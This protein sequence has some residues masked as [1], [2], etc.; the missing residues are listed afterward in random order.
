M[1]TPYYQDGD[2]SLY[3]ADASDLLDTIEAGSV[4]LAFLDFPYYK[5]KKLDWD[6]Q[7]TDVNA[8]LSWMSSILEKVKQVLAPNG[9]LY[10]CASPQMA[11]K[12]EGVVREHFNILNSI[13]WQKSDGT[14]SRADVTLYRSWLSAWET[15]IFAEQWWT[16]EI[17]Q[18]E[19]G[20]FSECKALHRQVYAPIGRYIQQERVR[21]E[22]AR[23]EI[24]VKL[25][26]VRTKNPSRGTELCRRWEEGSSLPNAETYERLR[27]LLNGQGN[28]GGSIYVKIMRNYDVTMNP[29]A[30]H[31][32]QLVTSTVTIST[33]LKSRQTTQNTRLKNRSRCSWMLWTFPTDLGLWAGGRRRLQPFSVD[34]ALLVVTFRSND[35]RRPWPD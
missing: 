15:V 24:E 27:D 26:Y 14:F 2:V 9:S 18:G 3:C 10:V 35:A 25:G 33:M 31:S 17:T 21:A 32:T 4:N 23:N 13:R 5:V 29:C 11:W 28:H 19:S 22:L 1:T 30:D 20:Y 16:D 34:G 7:W 8:F 12:V 6:N